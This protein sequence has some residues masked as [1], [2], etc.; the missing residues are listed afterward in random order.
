MA[1]GDLQNL[2][3]RHLAD[4][5]ERWKSGIEMF[6]TAVP[7]ARPPRA[8]GR[9]AHRT[10]AAG[11]ADDVQERVKTIRT[12]VYG[13]VHLTWDELFLLDSFYL[14]RLRNVS[15]MGLLHFVFPEARHSRFEHSLGVLWRAKQM[16]TTKYLRDALEDHSKHLRYAA[17]LHDIGHGPFSH[18]SERILKTLGLDRRLRGA[19][20]YHESRCRAMLT[21]RSVDG[22]EDFQLHRLALTTYGLKAFL[23]TAGCAPGYI[24]DLVN[25]AAGSTLAPIIN[26][27][28]DVDKLD[29]FS[30]DAYYT[31]AAPGGI[32]PERLLAMLRWKGLLGF[33]AKSIG[34]L[35]Q[36][37]YARYFTFAATIHHPVVRTVEAMLI[38]AFDIALE[39]LND[40]DAQANVM[41]H[42]ELM[43]DNDLMR[44]LETVS[45]ERGGTDEYGAALADI[46]KGLR[47]RRLWKRLLWFPAEAFEALANRGS[48]DRIFD[49]YSDREVV[50]FMSEKSGR[51]NEGPGQHRVP[52]ALALT[53][54]P[55][56]PEQTEQLLKK[57]ILFGDDGA[58]PLYE[59]CTG[60]TH[61][62][63]LV[64]LQRDL[65]NVWVLGPEVL[66]THIEGNKAAKEEFRKKVQKMVREPRGLRP[67]AAPYAVALGR[68]KNYGIVEKEVASDHGHKRSNRRSRRLDR[69]I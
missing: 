44:F 30:R 3:N 12:A 24:A 21:D 48:L 13:D 61:V 69:H 32:D 60:T 14:Q 57:I 58:R 64:D 42:L 22:A 55:R 28:V 50:W 49:D 8:S 27:P 54:R 19:V 36:F 45:S 7:S 33:E 2:V 4:V 40:P 65:W 38:V 23:E 68:L 31:G 43:D 47:S 29:Y 39:L 10:D 11:D 34:T 62:Q 59:R 6:R 26:G 56:S 15:Q 63:A 5:D 53:P 1:D 16:I 18:S 25:G 51:R 66:R 46:L 9:R 17:L 35:L 20:T 41:V 67:N 52:I 37:I